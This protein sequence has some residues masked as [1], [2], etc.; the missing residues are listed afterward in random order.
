VAAW[1]NAARAKKT[2]VVSGLAGAV[3]FASPHEERFEEPQ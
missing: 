3:T 2:T 1:G